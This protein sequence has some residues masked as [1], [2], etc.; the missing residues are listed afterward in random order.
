MNNKSFMGKLVDWYMDVGEKNERHILKCPLCGDKMNMNIKN[1]KNLLLFS[2][3]KPYW[4]CKECK[5]KCE[6]EEWYTI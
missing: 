5:I 4:E 3:K 2:K 6:V 1:N